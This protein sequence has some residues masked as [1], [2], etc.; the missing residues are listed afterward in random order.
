MKSLIAACLVLASTAWPHAQASFDRGHAEREV[1]AVLDDFMTAFN[2]RDAAAEERTYQF[3]HYRLA[4]GRMTVLNEAGAQ[5]QASMN[6]AYKSLAAGGWDHSGWTR[7]KIVHIS[8]NK[9]HVDTEFARYR[10]DG[11]IIGTYESLYVLTKEG[12]R[13]GIKLRSSFAQ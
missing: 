11:S 1:M 12:G 3:P 2:Q 7:R 9:A 10:R 13:W 8:D 4:S 5:T 6:A